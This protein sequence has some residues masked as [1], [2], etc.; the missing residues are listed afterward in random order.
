MYVWPFP[1]VKPPVSSYEAMV[2][3]CW[4]QVLPVGGI[5]EKTIAAKRADVNCLILPEVNKKDFDDL[6]NFIREGLEVHFVGCYPEVFD[7]IFTSDD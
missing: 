5:K 3:V 4:L 2:T 6:P 1:I 7:I